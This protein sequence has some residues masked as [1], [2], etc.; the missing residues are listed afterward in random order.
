MLEYSLTIR[1]EEGCTRHDVARLLRLQAARQERV[2]PK[3][4]VEEGDDGPVYDA[5]GRTRIGKWVVR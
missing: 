3:G 1:I 4:T 2:D 5:D